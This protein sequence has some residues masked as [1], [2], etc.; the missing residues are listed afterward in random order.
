MFDE[1][2]FDD[3]RHAA[4]AM[5]ADIARAYRHLENYRATYDH[6]EW[7]K[8]RRACWDAEGWYEPIEEIF[9]PFLGAE[10]EAL[11]NACDQLRRDL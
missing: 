7:D 9:L 2:I 1:A 5:R 10:G 3:A 4:Q 11:L 8:A 6:A